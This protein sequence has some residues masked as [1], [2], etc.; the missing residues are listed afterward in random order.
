MR[1]S[2]NSRKSSEHSINNLKMRDNM[3]GSRVGH[4]RPSTET[5]IRLDYDFS[6]NTTPTT[7]QKKMLG[8][9]QYSKY[10]FQPTYKID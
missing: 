8:P 5:C 6:K 9:K 2:M 3:K 7:L 4:S 1:K 10:R